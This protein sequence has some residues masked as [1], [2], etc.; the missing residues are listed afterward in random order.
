MKHLVSSYIFRMF[1]YFSLVIAV[2]LFVIVLITHLFVRSWQ[3]TEAG[4]VP[5]KTAVVLYAINHNVVSLDINLP[6]LMTKK[7]RVH[8]KRE[9]IDIPARDGTKLPALVFTP[10]N[11]LKDEKLPVILYFHGG[12]F[13]EGYGSIYSHENIMRALSLRTNS[14]VI[15]IGYRVAPTFTFPKAIEDSYD[16]LNYIYEHAEKFQGEKMKIAVAGDSAGGNI[17]AAVSKMAKDLNGPNIVAQVLY[18]P[19]T[20]FL[21]ED[22]S[23][24][25]KYASGYYLLSRTVMERARDAYTPESEMWTSPYASLLHADDL[26][27]LPPTFIITAEYDPLRDEGE[28]FA[29]K[30]YESGVPVEVLRFNGMMHGFVSFYEVMRGSNFALNKSVAYLKNIF[31]NKIEEKPFEVKV[32]NVEEEQ[33]YLLDTIEAY[34]IAMILLAKQARAMIIP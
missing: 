18:Y 3:K 17:A 30:L 21:D 12:A 25:Q 28:L 23:S 22:F 7:G 2:V 15:G 10:K 27:N 29:E 20:S 31:H 1:K 26:E 14:I 5:A 19:I 8:L 4:I 11:V 16:A 6:D 33:F 32:Y 24:R 34:I 13:L 9:I